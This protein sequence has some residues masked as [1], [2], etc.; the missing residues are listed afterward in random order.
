MAATMDLSLQAILEFLKKEHDIPEDDL[1]IALMDEDFDFDEESHA[2]W[3]DC[4]DNEIADDNGYTAGGETLSNVSVDINSSEKRV[5]ISADSVTW[6][7]SGGYIATT[8]SAVVYND[9]HSDKTVIGCITFDAN[10]DTPDGKLFQVNLSNGF[11]FLANKS[12]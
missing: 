10:Y 11:V 8:G 2:T 4:S 9:S 3:E 5:E 12:D 7:A 1:K 6:E